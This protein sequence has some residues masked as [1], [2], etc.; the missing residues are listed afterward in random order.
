MGFYAMGGRGRLRVRETY[1][2]DFVAPLLNSGAP[3]VVKVDLALRCLAVRD[4]EPGLVPREISWDAIHD[5]CRPVAYYGRATKLKR[6][7]VSD[8]LERL[9]GLGLVSRTLE[10][11][12]RSRLV[13]LRDD[14]SGRAADDPG[15][16]GGSYVSFLGDAFEYDRMSGWGSPQI[17]AFFAAMVA[18]RY[19][20]SDSQLDWIQDGR[21]LGGGVWFRP[22]EWFEDKAGLRPPHHVR[23][24]FSARTLRR[25]I[26]DLRS[27]GLIA[28]MRVREDPRTGLAFKSQHGRYVYFNYFND[29][30]GDR[31]ARKPDWDA[32]LRRNDDGDK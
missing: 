29:F 8:K 32:L 21:P 7:W 1:L 3:G 20:R 9:V 6:Q 25:G 24:G 5:L 15:A 4:G 2:R 27:E 18:E 22:L 16:D 12:S 17:A 13:V 30:R 23:I 28:S 26:Q 31:V 10:P 19:A 11:G 14:G